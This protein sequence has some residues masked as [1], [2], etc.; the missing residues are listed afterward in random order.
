[1]YTCLPVSCLKAVARRPADSCSTTHALA[2]AV[3]ADALLI[4]ISWGH[5]EHCQQQLGNLHARQQLRELYCHRRARSATHR[6]SART[7][8]YARAVR[9]LAPL[10]H[11]TV[12]KHRGR[13]TTE[14]WGR[15]Q[16]A[17]KGNCIIRFRG[18]RSGAKIKEIFPS[19]GYHTQSTIISHPGSPCPVRL[20]QLSLLAV[21]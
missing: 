21:R 11:C 1:M 15:R 14:L 10:E 16:G 9:S 8:T 6:R 19:R 2:I 5:T 13:C 18:V 12:S 20:P 17:R 7:T 3:C 4:F